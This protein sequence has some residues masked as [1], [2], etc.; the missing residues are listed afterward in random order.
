M[1]LNNPIWKTNFS[2]QWKR[3]ASDFYSPKNFASFPCFPNFQ[4]Q[5]WV[6]ANFKVTSLFSLNFFKF[7]F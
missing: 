5:S 4:F 1:I 6:L 3:T 2:V 7:E